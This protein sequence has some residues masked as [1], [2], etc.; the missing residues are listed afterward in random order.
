MIRDPAL[1]IGHSS[2]QCSQ[3]DYILG[4]LR[5]LMVS[6]RAMDLFNDR[7]TTLRRKLI[8]TVI[9]HFVKAYNELGTISSMTVGRA[10]CYCLHP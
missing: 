6:A 8:L 3:M 1:R 9:I 5:P 2:G 7:V 10:E 4:L